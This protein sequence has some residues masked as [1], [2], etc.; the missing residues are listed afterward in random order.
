MHFTDVAIR[1]LK[2]PRKDDKRNQIS[3]FDTLQTGLALVLVVSYGGTKSWR[4]ITYDQHSKAQATKI[5][6][7]PRLS[8]RDARQRAR[9]LFDNPEKFRAEVEVGSFGQVADN[10]IERHVAKNR[11]RSQREIERILNV[12]VLPRWVK[13]PFLEL[14]RMDVNKL[15]D[16][17]EDGNGPSQADAVLAV[18]RGIM[19]W[20]A[21][22]DESYVSPIVPKMR[23]D[24][25]KPGERS[26]KRVLEDNEIRAVWSAADGTFG[27]IVKILLLTGQRRT[28]T[29]KMR[30]ADIEDGVWTVPVEENRKGTV[31]RVALPAMALDIINEQ[32]RIAGN[33]Y[34]FPGRGNKPF[35][36]FSQAKKELDARLPVSI[37]HWRL[38]DLRRTARSL[39][40]R[41]DVR[42]D[43][44]ERL[45]GHAVVG[46]AA[47][48]DRHEYDD[49]KAD[50]LGK[51]AALIGR[52]VHPID[53]VVRHHNPVSAAP[54]QRGKVYD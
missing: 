3:Y 31:G 24:K 39:L 45:M 48:Y 28:R 53:S 18:V 22:R 32:P 7:Y 10:W 50:A 4:V 46:V 13:R 15:L 33:E 41:A 49:H 35:N 19:N 27:A 9:D 40:S 11:L 1:K 34:V 44:A 25:R 12:Y 30:W 26:R 23:R 42:P 37:P 14:R 17:I 36:H 43:I 6:V 29:V 51:L 2:L 5:G 54:K 8:L 52:I 47:V 20:F 21:S 38:H 16:E